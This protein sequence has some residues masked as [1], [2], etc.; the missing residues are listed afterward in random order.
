[1]R[2]L[3]VL[4]CAA[5][6]AH[7]AKLAATV[8]Y[9]DQNCGY[10]IP[11]TI[12]GSVYRLL[13]DTG[14]SNM[15]IAT[16]QC[17]SGCAGVSPLYSG[18][19]TA[20]QVSSYY[21]SGSFLGNLASV[22]M[23]LG[24]LTL[25]AVPF[26][27][28][29]QANGFFS[30]QG[31]ANHYEGIVGLGYDA[32]ESPGTTPFFDT[33]VNQGVPPVF[34]VQLCSQGG[35][36]WFGGVDTSYTAGAFSYTP[37]THP[38][39][40]EVGVSGF[41]VGGQAVSATS[42]APWILDTGTSYLVMASQTDYDALVNQMIAA[43]FVT[44]SQQLQQVFWSGQDGVLSSDMTVD[45]NYRVEVVFANSVAVQ[46]PVANFILPF[47]SGGSLYYAFSGIVLDTTIGLNILGVTFFQGLVVMFDRT[48]ASRVGFAVG[49]N[50]NTPAGSAGINLLPSSVHSNLEPAVWAVVVCL[51]LHLFL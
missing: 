21:A 1:M 29:T 38:S 6:V 22:L 25:P 26:I 49:Q 12:G 17:T 10:S 3:V 14:S 41:N 35:N 31:T 27:G 36:A 30:C 2:L 33:L 11:F 46:I 23:V 39:Y 8:L 47:Y 18:Y 5:S 4:L 45:W 13:L 24:S 42:T 51:L 40:Y 43:G 16:T 32:L 48:S 19:L 44:M 7:S 15:A 34:A 9:G 50:C 28:I 37:I 20:T